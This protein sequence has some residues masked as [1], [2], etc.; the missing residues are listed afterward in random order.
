MSQIRFSAAI[1]RLRARWRLHRMEWDG[2]LRPLQP[3]KGYEHMYTLEAV[4]PGLSEKWNKREST[5]EYIRDLKLAWRLYKH[6]YR[7]DPD[8]EKLLELLNESDQKERDRKVK[9]WIQEGIK[10]RD[11]TREAIDDMTTTLQEQK[12]EVERIVKNRVGVLRESLSEFSEG[13]RE[14]REQDLSFLQEMLSNAFTDIEDNT[15]NP[16]QAKPSNKDAENK[17]KIKNKDVI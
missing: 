3:P 5:E 6:D 17:M 13:Y 7:H 1:R 9:Q 11:K 2:M 8:M 14:G 15:N 4:F 12:P 16:N 10:M